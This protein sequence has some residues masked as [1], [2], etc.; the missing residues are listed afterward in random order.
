MRGRDCP[1]CYEA[2]DISHVYGIGVRS[3]EEGRESIYVMTVEYSCP[4]CSEKCI[5]LVKCDK[6]QLSPSDLYKSILATL[7]K[8]A[9]NRK[10]SQDSSSKISDKEVLALKKA[11]DNASSYEQILRYLGVSKLE[12]EDMDDEPE[13]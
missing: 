3:I 11:L 8:A 13:S 4:R 6:E 1:H 10:V 7:E 2:T 5:F 9:K 12:I